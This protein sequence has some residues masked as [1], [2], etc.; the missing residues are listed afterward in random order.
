[1]SPPESVGAEFGEVLADV[2]DDLFE[3]AVEFEGFGNEAV[4]GAG[5]RDSGLGATGEGDD[6]MRG[7]SNGDGMDGAPLLLDV[8]GEGTLL[9]R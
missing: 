5:H 4:V 6:M 2:V 3:L 7:D 8:K 1:M 9:R